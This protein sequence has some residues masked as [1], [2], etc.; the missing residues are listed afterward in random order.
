MESNITNNSFNEHRPRT[1]SSARWATFPIS[2]SYE[3]DKD[4]SKVLFSVLAT[5]A[6]VSVICSLG[7]CVVMLKSKMI[8]KNISNYFIFH[9]SI[10]ELLFLLVGTPLIVTFTTKKDPNPTQCKVEFFITRACAATIFSLL[11]GIALDRYFSIAHPLKQ[12]ASPVKHLHALSAAWIYAAV[13][14]APFLY[15]ADVIELEVVKSVTK[16]KNVSFILQATHN[17]YTTMININGN[18]S[19][20]YEISNASFPNL[21][22]LELL[23]IKHALLNISSHSQAS[24]TK[25]ERKYSCGIST[26]KAGQITFFAY[27]TLAFFAPLV[28]MVTTYLLTTVKLWR[29]SKAGTMSGVFAKSKI[30]SL[31]MLLLAVVTFSVTWGTVFIRDLLNATSV[32]D[33]PRMSKIALVVYALMG[34][35]YYLSPIINTA[36]YSFYNA[37]FRKEAKNTYVKVARMVSLSTEEHFSFRSR[38][39]GPPQ[40]ENNRKWLCTKV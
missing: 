39:R 20:Q 19:I 18:H 30:K 32:V 34:Y 26:D 29:R 35:T 4:F 14:A 24:A 1:T 23:R 7:I 10:T 25:T 11:S 9:L 21:E 31:R 33:V 40:Q 16:T 13:C 27:F 37:N 36:L 2:E 3:L 38:S 5:L 17:S 8:K 22:I 28:V 6:V 15:S 12:L